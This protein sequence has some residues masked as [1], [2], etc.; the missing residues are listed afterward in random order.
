MGLA[1]GRMLDT[2][3]D[4]SVGSKTRYSALKSACFLT[5]MRSAVVRHEDGC[6]ERRKILDGSWNRFTENHS[7]SRV[8]IR[9]CQIYN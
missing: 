3:L 1:S 4:S 5:L 7:V 2:S 8:S 6:L 9:D